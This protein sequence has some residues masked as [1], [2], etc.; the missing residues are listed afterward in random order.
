MKTINFTTARKRLIVHWLV[1]SAVIFIIYFAEA[2][3]GRFGP[4]E[5][6]VWGWLFKYLTPPLSLMIGVLIA[7]VSAQASDQQADL[8]YFRLTM[9]ISYFFLI[10]LF[11]SAFLV[12]VIH[13]QQNSNLV[14]S[15]Q[16][17]IIQAFNTYNSILLPV[18]GITTLTLGF[19]FSKK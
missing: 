13:L 1:A 10:V 12:P 16:Q 5:S 11:L 19:F 14:V 6:E 7:Q 4:H 9:G 18:Q 17:T 2:R 3:F 8:F 15:E